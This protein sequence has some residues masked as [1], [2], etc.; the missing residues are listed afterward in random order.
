MMKY[1]YILI[2]I[3][4]STVINGQEYL[5]GLISNPDI[6]SHLQDK[7]SNFYK[8]KIIYIQPLDL[9]FYDDFSS[10]DIYPDTALWLDNE[11]YIN[12]HFPVYP[13]NKGVAT[14][15]V[16]DANGNLYPEASPF[17]F[18]ADHLTSKPIRLDSIYDD[19]ISGYRKMEPADSVY[20]SFYYQPQGR[21]DIPLAH[22][23]LVLQF[24]LYN[25]DSSYVY[26]DSNLI[27]LDEVLQPGEVILPGDTLYYPSLGC[28]F[29]YTIIFD[30]LYPTDTAIVPCDSVFG[31]VTEWVSVWH[32]E[33]D[34]LDVF[35]DE[36][37]VFFKRMVI[38]ITDTSWLSS[39]FQFRFINYASTSNINSWMSNTDHWHIDMVSLA[40]NR[41]LDDSYSDNV[42]FADNPQS[43]IQDYYTM[44][45]RQYFYGFKKDSV[46]VFAHNL[47]SLEHNY[48][49]Y[50][51]VQDEN[52]DTMPAFG[53]NE[54]QGNLFPL[55]QQNANNFQPFVKSKVKYHFD[56]PP[57]DSTF[58]RISHVIYNNDEPEAADTTIFIQDF[59]NYFAYDDGS[60]EAG[61]GLSPAGS[62]MALKFETEE[63]D[64]L[65]GVRIYFNKTINNNNDRLFTIG[66]WFDNDGVPG[67]KE[68][69]LKNQRPHF[70]AINQFHT[71]V[72]PDTIIKLGRQVFYIGI[73]QTTNDNLNVGFDRNTDS[74]DKLFQNT[75]DGWVNSEFTGSLMIRP[76]LGRALVPGTFPEKSVQSVFKLYPNPPGSDGNVRIDLPAECSDEAYR[77]YLSIR[78]YDLYGRLLRQLPYT[79]EIST[80]FLKR[81][82]YIFNLLDGANSKSYSTKLYI[83]R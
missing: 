60:A 57:V 27:P 50:Y 74:H 36:N 66:L 1:F 15:D 10:D 31:A 70:Y 77:K 24:G 42:Y 26:T 29:E 67:N 37:D 63:A 81:G 33:G 35:V 18:I 64:T 76:L 17:Q 25:G 51:A 55:F 47:D 53:G 80:N 54:V 52:G 43:F 2:L 40:A 38:P 21:G 78:I 7:G 48:T 69:E 46:T 14:M 11:A 75:L 8:S 16:I 30:T 61:Y 68:Y 82:L 39:D 22:D 73:I 23:S 58:Y 49:Y 59:N 71:Y 19:N 20:F 62:M 28:D 3:I 79:E 83:A 72:F 44:P 34:T 56:I 5:S 32:A 65:R 13:I 4:V 6:K 45:A 41:T 9:P 12:N